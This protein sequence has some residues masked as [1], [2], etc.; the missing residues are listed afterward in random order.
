LGKEKANG[1]GE[2]M[3]S[4]EKKQY[5]IFCVPPQKQ[6]NNGTHCQQFN[7]HHSSFDSRCYD[8]IGKKLTLRVLSAAVQLSLII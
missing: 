7:F 4:E 8:L 3:N 1:Q 5:T 6:K 2:K